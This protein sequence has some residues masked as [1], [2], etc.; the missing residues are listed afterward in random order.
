MVSFSCN[1]S[2]SN[3]H[4][5]PHINIRSSFSDE[6]EIAFL[7]N[8]IYQLIK[9]EK[10]LSYRKKNEIH[11]LLTNRGIH[12]IFSERK[13]VGFMISYHLSKKMIEISGL[14]IKLEYRNNKLSDYLIDH[15]TSDPRF[16]YVAATFL[17]HI[18]VKLNNLG[19]EE[20]YLS[21]LSIKEKCTFFIKR[22]KIHRIKEVLR[23]KKNAD[24]FLM[25]K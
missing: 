18:K 20:I 12:C 19:F 3:D 6:D 9:N 15:V 24:L 11:D 17:E 7:E 23:H 4:K 5:L 21:S 16:N 1:N 10:N 8:E 14:Y 25:K 2:M 13:L 22:L